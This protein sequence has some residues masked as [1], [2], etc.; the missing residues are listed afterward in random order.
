MK[1]IKCLLK[2]KAFYYIAIV[3][4]LILIMG[5]LISIN[6]LP[7]ISTNVSDKTFHFFGYFLFS[8]LWFTAFF[9]NHKKPSYIALII[10]VSWASL[11]FGMIIELLQHWLTISRSG[12]IFDLLANFVGISIASILLLFSKKLLYKLKNLK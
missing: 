5:S 9:F 12:D 2:V 7:K 4:T 6:E 8:I 1:L 11:L 3:Y 10:F